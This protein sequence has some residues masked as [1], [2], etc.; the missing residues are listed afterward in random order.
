MSASVNKLP[1]ARIQFYGRRLKARESR[2]LLDGL[3]YLRGAYVGS[4]SVIYG[5]SARANKNR[6]TLDKKIEAIDLLIDEFRGKLVV[7]T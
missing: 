1:A 2:M 3:Y 7:N 4:R 5:D 6:R